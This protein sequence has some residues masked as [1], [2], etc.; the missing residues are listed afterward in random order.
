MGSHVIPLR[1]FKVVHYRN[2]L[3]LFILTEVNY[4][5]TTKRDHNCFEC[6]V[7]YSTPSK[8][9]RHNDGLSH[10]QKEMFSQNIFVTGRSSNVSNTAPQGTHHSEDGKAKGFD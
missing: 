7:S 9:A 4:T 5:M 6:G 3:D 2:Y 8:L 1:F 10:K